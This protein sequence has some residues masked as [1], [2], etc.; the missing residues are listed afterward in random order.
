MRQLWDGRHP[1]WDIPPRGDLSYRRTRNVISTSPYRHTTPTS[2]MIRG[3]ND[4]EAFE[5]GGY[6]FFDM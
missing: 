4:T 2:R 5:S 3:Y 6:C 1:A